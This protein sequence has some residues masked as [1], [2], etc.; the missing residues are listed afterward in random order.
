MA[1][2]VER[3]GRDFREKGI[4][5]SWDFTPE[6]LQDPENL[7]RYLR[8]RCCDSGRSEEVQIIWGLAYAYWALFSAIPDRERASETERVSEPRGR[9]SRSGKRVF[10]LRNRITRLREASPTDF[11]KLRRKVSKLKGKT[12]NLSQTPSEPSKTVSKQNKTAFNL[13]WSYL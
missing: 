6:H 2:S 9:I 3:L 8:Q 7:N 12:S 13:S 4:P 5:V 10:L 1:G 11:S